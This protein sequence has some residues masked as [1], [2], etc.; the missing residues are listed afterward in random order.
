MEPELLN[1]GNSEIRNWIA[2]AAACRDQA[3]QWDEYVPVY[4][5]PVGTGVGLAFAYWAAD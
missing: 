5:T 1:A 2:V 3:V 4:R